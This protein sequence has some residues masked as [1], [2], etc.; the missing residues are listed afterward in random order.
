MIENQHNHES[1]ITSYVQ[2]LSMY[3][4]TYLYLSRHT[5]IVTHFASRWLL[6]LLLSAF[7]TPFI[8]ALTLVGHQVLDLLHGCTTRQAEEQFMISH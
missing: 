2:L 8:A 4:S 3:V 6:G 7:H 1:I 5:L